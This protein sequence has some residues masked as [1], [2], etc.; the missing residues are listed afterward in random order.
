M[1][2]MSHAFVLITVS[3]FSQ[4]LMT[5]T[6]LKSTPQ[7]CDHFNLSVKPRLKVSLWFHMYPDHQDSKCIQCASCIPCTFPYGQV[8]NTVQQT[9]TRMETWLCEEW[10]EHVFQIFSI[11][12]LGPQPAHELPVK[13]GHTWGGKDG[14]WHTGQ[15]VSCLLDL[16]SVQCSWDANNCCFWVWEGGREKEQERQDPLLSPFSKNDWFILPMTHIAAERG[17][18]E[19]K[20]LRD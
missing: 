20:H 6:S 3:T 2:E 18:Q 19:C 10:A 4:N 9:K 17:S 1:V 12:Q 8:I 11:P 7:F 16:K 15:A 13:R 5:S 14:R